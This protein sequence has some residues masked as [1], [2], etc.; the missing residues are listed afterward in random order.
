MLEKYKLSLLF[1]VP[2]C[3][4]YVNVLLVIV[5]CLFR[6][7]FMLVIVI[8]MVDYCLKSKVAITF[9]FFLR[10]FFLAFLRLLQSV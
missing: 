1:Y 3:K 4:C 10:L 8:F 6:T 5:M 7:W 2:K 9:L